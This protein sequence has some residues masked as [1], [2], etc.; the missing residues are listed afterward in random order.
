MVEEVTKVANK[1]R[2]FLRD[3]PYFQPNSPI[4][5]LGMVAVLA[6]I[7][8]ALAVTNPALAPVVVVIDLLSASD[9]SP[10]MLVAIGVSIMGLKADVSKPV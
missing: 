3:T 4:W 1:W 10:G 7:I 9:M 8:K 5:W 2:E 6:G